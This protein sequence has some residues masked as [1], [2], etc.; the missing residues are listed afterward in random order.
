MA[1]S[2]ARLAASLL[3]IFVAKS[4][5]RSVET[6]EEKWAEAYDRYARAAEDVSGEGPATV[7]AAGFRQA[8]DF[9]SA[10]TAADFCRQFER[11]FVA[12][13][14]AAV[15]QVGTPPPPTPPCPNVGGTAI[16]SSETSSVVSAVTPQV[17][18]RQLLPQISMVPPRATPEER[19]A[20]IAGAMH[21]ATVSAV[22]VLITGLDTTPPPAGPL[23][24]T[25]V[26]TIR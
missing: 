14:T 17:M 1:L 4:G 9:R 15:F 3:D 21:R 24:V 11:A 6:F 7:N 25:N 13:W 8:L 19:A 22:L 23:P 2:Q 18:F 20:A 10:R 12:Y 26:C 16:F 5:I